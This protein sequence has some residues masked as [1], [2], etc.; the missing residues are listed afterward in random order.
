MA[1]VNIFLF[2]YVYN[3]KEQVNH[4]VD[5]HTATHVFPGWFSP[6]WVESDIKQEEVE[7]M[8]SVHRE[9]QGAMTETRQGKMTSEIH[10]IKK[11]GHGKKLNLRF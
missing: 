3:L 4:T 7:P 6:L 1:G 11:N 8:S 2:L 5:C 10:C 9:P